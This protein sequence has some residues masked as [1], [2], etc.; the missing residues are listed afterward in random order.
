[1]TAFQT[2][3]MLD[4]A[5]DDAFDVFLRNRHIG[6][7]AKASTNAVRVYFNSTATAGST[8]RF[9]NAQ[10]AIGYLVERRERLI[11]KRAA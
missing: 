6:I 1:M 8:R 3:A 10:A 7:V 4:W 11:A 2:A 9:P 5:G